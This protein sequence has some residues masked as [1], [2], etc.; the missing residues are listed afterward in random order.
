MREIII[1]G[2]SVSPSVRAVLLTARTINLEFHYEPIDVFNQEHLTIEFMRMN[3]RHTVP[4]LDDNGFIL[5]D[6]HAICQYLVDTYAFSH[7][8]FP[9]DVKSRALINERLFFNSN[10]L[11]P[12][13]QQITVSI[14][15]FYVVTYGPS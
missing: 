2:A 15:L 14:H 8:L 9:E 12:Q 4:V 13:L 7:S 1:Y 3:P 10:I 5:C 11:S 6:A